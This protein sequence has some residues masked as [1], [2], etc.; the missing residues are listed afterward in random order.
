[1]SEVMSAQ[2]VADHLG[3]AEKT[4]R[5]WIERKQLPAEREGHA[6]Q[7]RL[8]DAE[9][10]FARTFAGRAVKRVSATVDSQERELADAQAELAQLRGRYNELRERV[11]VLQ[12]ER[13]EAVR[14][15]MRM[16]L[17]RELRAPRAA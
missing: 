8:D 2:Q 3:V 13:D 5:R 10:V 7:I 16:E 17:E 11:D 14:A 4:V 1:M 6:F 15:L 12:A 9:A